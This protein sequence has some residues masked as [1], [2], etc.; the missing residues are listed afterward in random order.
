LYR[1]FGGGDFE[2]NWFSI[3][4]WHLLPGID[5]PNY[6]IRREQDGDQSWTDRKC[7]NNGK[8]IGGTG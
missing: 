8:G 2:M 5:D 4:K 3:I 6:E 1:V 7:S